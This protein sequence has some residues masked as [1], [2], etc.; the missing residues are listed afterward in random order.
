MTPEAQTQIINA[1]IA[2]GPAIITAIGGV[3]TTVIAYVVGL[4]KPQPQARKPKAQK[5]KP[6]AGR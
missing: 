3:I 4:N 5:D 1:L 6:D 2:N